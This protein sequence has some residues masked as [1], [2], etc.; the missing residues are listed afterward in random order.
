VE[1]ERIEPALTA[2]EWEK[3]LATPFDGKLPRY[4]TG[5]DRHALAA[6]LLYGQPFGFTQRDFD[7]IAEVCEKL[8]VKPQFWL[9]DSAEIGL[10]ARKIAALLPPRTP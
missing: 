10:V 6:V 2:E 3:A 1:T 4:A 7:V 9:P 8:M 5:A